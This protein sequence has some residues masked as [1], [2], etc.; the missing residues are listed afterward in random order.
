V[1]GALYPPGVLHEDVFNTDLAEKLCPH[2]DDIWFK[3]MAFRKGTR[4]VATS[5]T[6][7]HLP[8]IQGSQLYNLQTKNVGSG[9]NDLQIS[10]VTGQFSILPK[11]FF[12]SE[13]DCKDL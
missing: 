1:S 12:N 6:A 10:A 9:G 7:P 8:Q 11:S 5:F 4:G 2:A 3:V 13:A